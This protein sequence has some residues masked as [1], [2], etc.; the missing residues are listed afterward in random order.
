MNKDVD[1]IIYKYKH[2]LE[3]IDVMAELM[4]LFIHYRIFGSNNKIFYR[5]SSYVLTSNV[6]RQYYIKYSII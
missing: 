1:S 3:H 2:N 6:I 5:I 4:L